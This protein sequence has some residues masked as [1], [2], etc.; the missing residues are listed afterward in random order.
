[1]S[2]LDRAISN[3]GKLFLCFLFCFVASTAHSQV[4]QGSVTGSVRDLQKNVVAGATV[5]IENT[6][7]NLT[8]TRQTGNSGDYNFTPLKIGNYTVTVSAPGFATIIQQ[9]VHVDV[10]QTVGLNFSLKPGAVNE[11][12]TVTSEPDMQTEEASTGQVFSAAVVN[13]LPLDGRNYV[14]A[15]QLTTGVAAPNQGFTQVAGSGTSPRTETAS[16][17]TTSSSTVS[18][19]TRTCRTS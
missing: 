8:L 1:M 3:V 16:R 7:T 19:T 17:K 11:S 2:A 13:D 18:T 15:A 9:N 6:D 5:T 14:F 12:V 10:S 4:D